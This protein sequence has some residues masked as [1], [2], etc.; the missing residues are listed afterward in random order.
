MCRR[1]FADGKPTPGCLKRLSLELCTLFK[2]AWPQSTSQVTSFFPGL[3]VLAAVGHL[4]NGA[5]LVGAAGV[6]SMYANFADK[7]MLVSTLFGAMPLFSQAFGAGN[8]TRVGL[9]LMRV[10]VLHICLAV[11]V[12]LPLT[13]AA[14]ALFTAVG[15]P[16]T[17]VEPAQTFLW[18]RLLGVPGLIVFLDIQSFLT[19]QRCVKLPMLVMVVGAFA[20]VALVSVLTAPSALGFEGSAWALSLVELGQGVALACATPWLL[21]RRKLR[22]WPAWRRDARQA[23]KGWA[24]IVARGGPACV[25]IIS[26][27]GGWE[28]TLF[29]A[30]GLCPPPMAVLSNAT[31]APAAGDGSS[32]CPA[33]EA[34]PICTSIFVCQFFLAFGPGLA[35]NVRIG[36]LL[37]E[38]RPQDAVY[39]AKVAGAMAM[40]AQVALSAAV[41]TFRWQ[42]AEAFVEDPLVLEHVVALLPY[43]TAYSF[44]AT[45]VSGFSQQLLFGLG[46]PL[47]LPAVVNLFSFFAVGMPVG[48]L[49]AYRGGLAERG[50]W[51]GLIIAMLIALVGQYAYLAI[52]VDWGEAAN[53][54]RARALGEESPQ[55]CGA[56]P[57]SCNSAASG[58]G[59]GESAGRGLAAAD[60]AAE[61]AA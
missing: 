54:A 18:I 13:A 30:G 56:Q 2:L 4:E 20:Q 58:T 17:V 59:G 24:E 48:T 6:A 28:G 34:I 45:A 55:R 43:T 49:L 32:G 1:S 14:G 41:L 47:H 27:W 46:A 12:S 53:R 52:A 23:C 31:S 61:A 57:T 29:I 10:L 51:L 40:S 5:V 36:N 33:I 8:H 26:E 25:M 19:A 39:C 9:V 7:M 16:A 15:L 60:S 11:C 21:H 38:G 3:V 35:A 50:I 37:G 44:L 42:I 22:S